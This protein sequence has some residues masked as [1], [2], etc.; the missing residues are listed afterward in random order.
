MVTWDAELYRQF[1]EQ[2]TQ[3]ARDLLQRVSPQV[4]GDVIDLGCGPGNSTELLV[5]KIPGG[6]CHRPR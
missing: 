5:A 6:Q 3:P 2:R 1:E 4:Q